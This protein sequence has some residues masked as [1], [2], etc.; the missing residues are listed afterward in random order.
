MPYK[1]VFLD[2]QQARNME[3]TLN[4]MEKDGWAFQQAYSYSNR[5]SGES[6]YNHTLIFQRK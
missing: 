2:H 1:V 5:G 3:E 4:E 6:S